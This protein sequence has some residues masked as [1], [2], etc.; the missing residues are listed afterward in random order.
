MTD[1]V[2]FAR[3]IM[4]TIILPVAFMGGLWRRVG[5][6]PEEEAIQ[7]IAVAFYRAFENPMIADLLSLYY[8][9]ALISFI[10]AIILVTL[11]AHAPGFIAFWLAYLGGYLLLPLPEIGVLLLAL[12]WV[13]VLIG[14]AIRAKDNFGKRD[15][16][17][18]G[19]GRYR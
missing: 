10:G 12:S 19:S 16:S 13:L 8:T 3:G 4:V 7:G 17:T 5:I 6:D 9:V 14:V 11:T 18:Y 15:L 2:D 1:L